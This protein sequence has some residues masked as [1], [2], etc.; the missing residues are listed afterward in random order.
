[1]VLSGS[2]P[3]IRELLRKATGELFDE[4]DPAKGFTG[5]DLKARDM[6]I[7]II[8]PM[9]QSAGE[10]QALNAA[11]AS[12]VIQLLKEGKVSFQEAKELM[13]IVQMQFEM[14]ELRDLANR[15][16]GLSQVDSDAA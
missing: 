5:Y 16:D 9:L 10:I 1:M 11:S 7:S 15:L 3:I 4:R 2:M 12:E 8:T 14:D 13:S 6:V